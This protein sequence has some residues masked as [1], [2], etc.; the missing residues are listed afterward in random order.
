V[1]SKISGITI[2]VIIII[3]TTYV[4]TFVII[5]III[6]IIINYW[7]II[8]NIELLLEHFNRKEFWLCIIITLYLIN[9]RHRGLT[10]LIIIIGAWLA[11]L[12]LLYQ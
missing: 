5:I 1:S 9:N 6:I 8:I 11:L 2:V 3:T 10:C 4:L 7:I 12:L